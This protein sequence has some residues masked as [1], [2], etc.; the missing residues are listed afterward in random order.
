MRKLGAKSL[1][2]LLVGGGVATA[3]WSRSEQI[4]SPFEEPEVVSSEDSK[5]VFET[6]HRN[7]YRAFDYGTEDEVYSALDASI[8]G[9]LLKDVYLNIRK[10]LEVREQ[11]GA[12]A[13][14]RSVD[15]KS[16][17]VEKEKDQQRSPPWPGYKFKSTWQV[18]GTIEHWG[19]IHER[20]N[21]FEGVFT[22]ALEGEDWK[23]TE[24]EIVDEKR[25]RSKT[26]PRKF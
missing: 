13:R 6:L 1:L 19:H 3:T 15:Y 21:E 26:R 24:F 23:L 9:E 2:L 14:I 11:G 4:D 12:A 22:V 10:S 8:S 16:G 5:Q 18:S 17:D 20:I 25:I 7:V